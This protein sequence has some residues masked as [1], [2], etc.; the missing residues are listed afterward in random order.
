MKTF[1]EPHPYEN[2]TITVMLKPQ[3]RKKEY[4][5]KAQ[6]RTKIEK[7]GET[8]EFLVYL[9]GLGLQ[10][11]D[12]QDYLDMCANI[13]QG[14]RIDR[15]NAERFDFKSEIIHSSEDMHSEKEIGLNFH[16]FT[17]KGN[18]KSTLY[19]RRF[20]LNKPNVDINGEPNGNDTIFDITVVGRSKQKKLAGFK[21]KLEISNFVNSIQELVML[22]DIFYYFGLDPKDKSV[23]DMKLILLEGDLT[24]T[25]DGNHNETSAILF[26]LDT[27]NDFRRTFMDEK[28]PNKKLILTINKAKHN[29]ILNLSTVQGQ[30]GWY[31]NQSFLGVDDTELQSYFNSHQNVLEAISAKLERI[32]RQGVPEHKNLIPEAAKTDKINEKVNLMEEAMRLMQKGKLTFPEDVIV[33]NLSTEEITQYIEESKN[34]KVSDKGTGLFKRQ[35]EDESGVTYRFRILKVLEDNVDKGNISLAE[36]TNIKKLKVNEI[37]SYLSEYEKSLTNPSAE[38]EG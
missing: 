25:N 31:Y 4:P 3:F 36:G 28:N 16:G 21:E 10:K 7:D 18:D 14:D 5:V 1:Q 35:S 34:P 2:E 26:S 8:K 24:F 19:K 29:G 11:M 27:S 9:N 17:F 6:Y 15:I 23:D 33:S 20:W 13:K 38:V 12:M 22:Q 32:G 37:E 30:T